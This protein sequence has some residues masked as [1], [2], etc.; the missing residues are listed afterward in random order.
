MCNKEVSAIFN[1]ESLTSSSMDCEAVFAA[2]ALERTVF[3]GA[4][5]SLFYKRII[6]GV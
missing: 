1:K 6:F 4:E 5:P 2:Y 3:W